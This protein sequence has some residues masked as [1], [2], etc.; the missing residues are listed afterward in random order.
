MTA[1]YF[2][3]ALSAWAFGGAAV[4]GWV[5]ARHPYW[6]AATRWFVTL[7]F[8]VAMPF[9][10]VEHRVFRAFA[11]P[12]LPEARVVSIRGKELLE[13]GEHDDRDSEC[14]DLSTPR[15]RPVRRG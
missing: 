5:R 13:P 14:R 9:L 4:H 11:C 8:P 1:I 15:V 7:L 6:D 12:Q 10:L 3:L 2:L